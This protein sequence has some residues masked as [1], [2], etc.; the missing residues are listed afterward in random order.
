MGF[1][2]KA[3]KDMKESAKA[4][5]E[6]DKAEFEAVKAESKAS[7]EE[8]RGHNTFARAKEQAKQSWD[9]AHMTPAERAAKEQE[10]RDGKI[11]EAKERTKQANARYDAAKK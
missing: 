11:A 7:F 3:F 1:F 9:D 4:Q 10:T 2:K 8:N 6:V 5:H